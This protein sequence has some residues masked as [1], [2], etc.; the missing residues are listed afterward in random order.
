MA[1]SSG[2]RSSPFLASVLIGS[3]PCCSISRASFSSDERLPASLSSG[4]MPTVG[5]GANCVIS[6]MIPRDFPSCYHSSMR[7]RVVLF[8]HLL[9]ILV[10]LLGPGAV[11]SIV[12]ESLLLKHQLL[13]LNRSRQRSPNLCAWDRILASRLRSVHCCLVR[14]ESETQLSFTERLPINSVI[15]SVVHVPEV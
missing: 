5:V 7:H 3:T 9:A 15:R 14:T 10:R 2:I 8:L 4:H 12:A 6:L 1:A 13:L 11:R